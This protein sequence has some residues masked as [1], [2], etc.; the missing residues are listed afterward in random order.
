MDWNRYNTLV[1]RFGRAP[2]K[3]LFSLQ[4]PERK[5]AAVRCRGHAQRLGVGYGFGAAR[6]IPVP[7]LGLLLGFR[8]ACGAN[9]KRLRRGNRRHNVYC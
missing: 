7:I 5:Q 1:H 8:A 9:E 2:P 4:N 6:Q 3:R